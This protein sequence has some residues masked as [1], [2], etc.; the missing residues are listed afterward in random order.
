MAESVIVARGLAKRYGDVTALD[1]VDLAIEA[2]SIYALLGPNGAGKT[3][4]INIL[5]TLAQPSA[6]SAQVAGFDLARQPDEVRKRI[7]VT[8]QDLVLDPDLSG[9]QVLDIHRS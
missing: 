3:T 2:G 6:G 8:F 5:T 1:G 9:R 7:G 4:T